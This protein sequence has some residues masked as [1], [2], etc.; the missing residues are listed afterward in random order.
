MLF[1]LALIAVL[2]VISLSLGAQVSDITPYDPRDER[3]VEKELKAEIHFNSVEDSDEYTQ[4]IID[5]LNQAQESI[6]LAIYSIDS[7]EIVDILEQK[8]QQGLEVEVI[9]P[10]TKS[11]QHSRL[12]RGTNITLYEIGTETEVTEEDISTMGPELMHHKFLIT[13]YG[14]E[15]QHLLVSS[16]NITE[17]QQIYDPGFMFITQDPLL[18]DTFYHEFSLLKKEIHGLDKFSSG[19]FNPFSLRADYNNGTF[20]VWF[21]PG[22]LRNSVKTRLL[23][24]ISKAQER[25]DILAWRI[26]DRDIVRALMRKASEGIDVRIIADDYYLWNNES[27]LNITEH[28][29]LLHITSDSFTNIT[30]REKN[31]LEASL[32]ERDFN[33]FLHHHTMMVDENILITGTNN[34]T[35]RGFFYNDESILITDISTLVETYQDE[36]ERLYAELVGGSLRFSLEENRITFSELPETTSEIILYQEN[37]NQSL[38]GE[39]C[40]RISPEHINHE[41]ALPE[42]CLKDSVRIF[43]VDINMNLLESAYLYY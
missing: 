31:L 43:I 4:H 21:G 32:L 36:F 38:I 42:E 17:V 11:D 5:I 16:S 18:M 6:H 12:F 28:S 22:Y 23:D 29:E 9:V 20:E 41:I 13:D 40:M 39:I 25:I 33:A 8:S 3:R 1:S 19:E 26:N 27:S 37:H 15:N 35:Q 24:E 7:Q 2:S 34:W 14:A 30:L 10:S